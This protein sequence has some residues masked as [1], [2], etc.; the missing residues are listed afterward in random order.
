[1]TEDTFEHETIKFL[2][3]VRE[4]DPGHVYECFLPLYLVANQLHSHGFEGEEYER[5]I[6]KSF[7]YYIGKWTDWGESSKELSI[8]D[9]YWLSVIAIDVG[10]KK[11]WDAILYQKVNNDYQGFESNIDKYKQ[12]GV[13][14]MDLATIDIAALLFD[15]PI[16]LSNLPPGHPFWKVHGVNTRT[17]WE[18]LDLLEKRIRTAVNLAAV[19]KT[20][21]ILG[22]NSFI[23]NGTSDNSFYKDEIVESNKYGQ[24]D[25]RDLSL[26]DEDPL[27][28]FAEL[29][30][31]DLKKFTTGELLRLTD[32]CNAFDSGIV[33]SSKTGISFTAF[34][35]EKS[36][37]EKTQRSRLFK[38][39]RK[40]S[41]K[42]NK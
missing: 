28:A 6:T 13:L 29:A 17:E 33:K 1:M 41:N 23:N 40:L 14:P 39:V 12:S 35:G 9:I 10:V 24:N 42:L 5:R 11:L 7:N 18:K 20:Y 2:Y 4:Y 36:D 25:P 3:R 38:K 15:K 31:I 21:F 8:L 34:Y 19:M 26:K 27:E 32:L 37:S 30:G 16:R 22:Q